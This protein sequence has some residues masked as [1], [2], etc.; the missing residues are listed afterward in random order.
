MVFVMLTDKNGMTLP[1]CPQI[2]SDIDPDMDNDALNQA[3]ARKMLINSQFVIRKGDTDYD[4]Y[5]Q[6]VK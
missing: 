5:G 4:I 1:S 6:K 2:L 3:P